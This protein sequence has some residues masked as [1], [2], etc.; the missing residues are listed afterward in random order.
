MGFLWGGVGWGG[1]KGFILVLFT[2]S[3]IPGIRD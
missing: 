2:R 3:R 1:E